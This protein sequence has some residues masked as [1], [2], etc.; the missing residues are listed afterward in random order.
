MSEEK[1]Y[2]F[3]PEGWRD[4]SKRLDVFYDCRDKTHC[5]SVCTAR[6][7]EDGRMIADAL[8]LRA[9]SQ[10]REEELEKMRAAFSKTCHCFANNPK[11]IS[12]QSHS[13]LCEYGNY[14]SPLD[15]L[16]TGAKE[17]KA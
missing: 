10:S 15:D 1:V 6:T 12:T 3:D 16:A 5:V 2:R 14:L 17:K 7:E 4:T 11:K 8:N 13:G 9:A